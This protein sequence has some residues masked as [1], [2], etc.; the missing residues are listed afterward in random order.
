[1]NMTEIIC[2]VWLYEVE[3]NVIIYSDRENG[4]ILRGNAAQQYS[5]HISTAHCLWSAKNCIMNIAVAQS[6]GP[7]CAINASLAGVFE[8]G[9]NSQEIGVIYGSFNG[10]EGIINERLTDLSEHLK[11]QDDIELLTRTPSA[12]L[13]SCRRKLPEY[14]QNP[15]LYESITRCF[16]K[17]DIRIFLYIGGNDSMDTVAKLSRYYAEKSIDIKVIGIPKTI[18]ND[19]CSTDHCPGFGSA[20][21]YVAATVQEITRDSNVYSVPSVTIV[22]T[23]GRHAGWLTAAAGCMKLNGESAPHLIYLPEHVFCGERFL[24][25][26]SD[27]MKR[28]KAI[29]CAV[30]EGVRTADG[31]FAAEDYQSCKTDAFGH[32]YLSG[33]GKY[34]ENLVSERIGCKVRS[35]ELNVMQRCSSH[36]ASLTDIEEAREIGAAAVETGI[37]GKTGCMMAFKRISSVPYKYEIVSVPASEAANSERFFPAEWINSAGN[38]ITNEALEYLMPLIQGELPPIMKNGMPQHFQ[39]R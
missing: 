33:I 12:A 29:V 2:Y 13:G 37:S 24:S 34:L 4:Q 38:D 7:T 28:N 36:F 31:K 3:N 5:T 8:A 10:I 27:M 20:A 26:V 6:G 14:E 15:E 39:F 21:K 19:L 18:D 30:S 25:D 22:E 11:T 1:M 9:K 32:S 17:Y 35:I 23:M 16:K